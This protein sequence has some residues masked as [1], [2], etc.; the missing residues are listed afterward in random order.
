VGV[1]VR[2]TCAYPRHRWLGVRGRVKGRVGV[3]VGVWVGVN[4]RLGDGLPRARARAGV[5]VR[6][7]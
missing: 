5:V 6:V 7:G 2:V 3:G 1:G 4:A